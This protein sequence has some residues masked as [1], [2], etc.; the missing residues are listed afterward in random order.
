MTREEIMV[1][2]MDE[3]EN[4]RAEIANEV[5][6][7]DAEMLETLNA[8]L[9]AIEERTKALNIEIEEKRKAAAAVAGG[10]GE[11]IETRKEE[12]KMPNSEIRNSHEYIEA[13]AKYVKTGKD[14]ECRALLTEN[15]QDGVVPVPELVESRVRQAW[16]ND[17]IFR[18]ISKTF[19]RGNLKVGFEISATDAAIHTEGANAPDEETLVLGIVTMVP[20]NIKKWIT[21]SDEVL[22]LGAE[23][24]LRYI[25]DELTYKI[26]QKA[27]DMVV[28]AIQSAPETS[29]ADEVGVAVV[30][31]DVTPANILL[32]IAELGDVAR[33]RVFI[34]S[35]ATIAAVRTAALEANYAYDPFFGL[36]VIQKDGVDGAIVGDLA[37]VQANLPEGDAVTFK[38][39]DLSLAEKDM[40]KIVGRLYA[41]IAVVGPKM[42]CNIV[43]GSE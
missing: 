26:I 27:A 8:E 1:L 32:A 40:V 12:K 30:E 35:G 4:R 20:A 5:E 16:E 22:A 41:A 13:F 36:E 37:G 15:V 24:F 43:P 2:G 25:Y 34:A 6:T 9:D 38:F 33:N 11:V 42:F 29:D 23:D 21:V 3:I 17:Q 18:R 10:A 19:V 14:A 28:D 7:A 31:G 39:D